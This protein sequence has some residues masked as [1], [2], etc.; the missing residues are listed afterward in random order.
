M[1]NLIKIIVAIS[2][3]SLCGCGGYGYHNPQV[4]E[5]QG[6]GVFS[7]SEDGVVVYDSKTKEGVFN[8]IML[9]EKAE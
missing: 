4:N 8:R 5:P 6:P 9:K 2:L 1:S 3:I 7:D